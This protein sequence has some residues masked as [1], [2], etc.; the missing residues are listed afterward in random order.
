MMLPMML[1]LRLL[2]LNVGPKFVPAVRIRGINPDSLAARPGSLFRDWFVM[3]EICFFQVEL[4]EPT[5][6]STSRL[7]DQEGT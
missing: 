6:C 2:G 1:R 7:Q 4:C 3:V 5:Y